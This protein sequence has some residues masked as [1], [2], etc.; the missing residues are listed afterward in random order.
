M[1]LS[2]ETFKELY[3][4]IQSGDFES[5]RSLAAEYGVNRNCIYLIR[6][7][8]HRFSSMIG[9]H[10]NSKE[11]I[12]FPELELDE[13]KP[14]KYTRCSKCKNKVQAGIPCYICVVREFKY[15]KANKI[16][17]R[18]NAETIKKPD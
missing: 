5:D 11:T 8:K 10:S 1:G 6:Q 13:E 12:I 14:L 3:V 4:R 18:L 7:G 16:V 9:S 2:F 15:G 17:E